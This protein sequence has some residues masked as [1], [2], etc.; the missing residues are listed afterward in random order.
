VFVAAW[1]WRQWS[2]SLP[3]RRV[4]LFAGFWLALLMLQSGLVRSDHQHVLMGIYPMV[5]L[6]GAIALQEQRSRLLSIGLFAATV[7]ATVIF[8]SPSP[9]FRPADA[10]GR[11]RQ[12]WQQASMCPAGTVEFDHA[13]LFSDD[14]ELLR[15]VSEYVRAQAPSGAMIAVFPYQTAFGLSS[16][17][18][19]AGGVLQ[20]YLI[21][22]EYLTDMELS[23]LQKARPTLALYLPD[24][25]AGGKRLHNRIS[26]DVDGVLNFTRSPEL[27]FYY[28]QHYRTQGSPSPGVYSLTRDDS[29]V[30]RV[31]F[32]ERELLS[33]PAPVRVRQR[34]FSIDLGRPQC[35][36][37]AADFVRIRLRVDYPLWW[38]LRKPSHLAFEL[39]YLDGSRKS[40]A[41]VVAPNHTT[42][43]WIYP[44][45][46]KEMGR[47]FSE[48]EQQWRDDTRP[49]LTGIKLIIAPYDWMSVVPDT[50]TVEAATAV[51]LSLAQSTPANFKP[52]VQAGNAYE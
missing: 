46:E 23:A 9:A 19:V 38:R 28:V 6:C 30:A 35:P 42:D 12:T 5:F 51:K 50:V 22:G 10:M 17:H 25:E 11:W 31:S 13:C 44:W 3:G 1:H 16:R 33:L 27:W 8:A 45:N 49:E 21:N 43:I 15:K 26:L 52:T 2:S 24:R 39:S 47:Y 29:R 32:Q 20:G 4:F 34:H 48:D 41:F 7:I 37:S 14:A 18:Q 40:I 36:P